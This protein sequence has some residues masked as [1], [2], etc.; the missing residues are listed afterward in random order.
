MSKKTS[1]KEDDG[2]KLVTKYIGTA[3]DNVKT[4]A[5]NIDNVNNVAPI[6]ED[7]NSIIANIDAI[8]AS[9]VNSLAAE[10]SAQVA[11]LSETNASNSENNAAISEGNAAT[12][13]INS[14]AYA[15]SASLSESEAETSKDT[16]VA[17][18]TTATNERVLAET[19]RTESEAAEAAALVSETNSQILYDAMASL[20]DNFDDRYLGP[21]TT[22]PTLD[23]DGDVLLVGASYF[24][25]T[26]GEL[27]FW[28]GGQW[29]SPEA[30]A[31]SSAANAAVSETN[32][33]ASALAASG[34]ETNTSNDVISTAADRVQTGNDATAT[35]ADR[36]A[37]NND[38]IAT[39]ADRVQTESDAVSTASDRSAASSSA[40]AASFSASN[41]S[42]SESNAAASA[43]SIDDSQVN[44]DRA[45]KWRD[46]DGF[47][48]GGG[49]HSFT[50]PTSWGTVGGSTKLYKKSADGS[51]TL[52]SPLV[53]GQVYSFFSYTFLSTDVV[54][55]SDSRQ[56]IEI[57]AQEVTGFVGATKTYVANSNLYSNYIALD[58]N[59]T[60]NT[61]ESIGPTGSGANNIWTA[62]DNI[63]PDATYL[64][65]KASIE[66]FS[67][68]NTSDTNLYV[69]IHS[70]L[71]SEQVRLNLK[72]QPTTTS[73]DGDTSLT[74]MIPLD[75]NNTFSAL[76]RDFANNAS[77]FNCDLRVMSFG[78]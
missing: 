40:S 59:L 77:S 6:A 1:F 4:V 20:F 26:D 74:V 60:E 16:A 38:A 28:D 55:V 17:N 32:A 45:Y 70:N 27:K 65:L 75:D 36:V 8:V 9:E 14:Q 68:T 72:Y 50:V 23:N 71:S 66:V 15:D 48:A 78:I 35:A 49:G 11:A 53:N 51:I 76:W 56:V 34:S 12:S 39:A 69:I 19:A 42:T 73:S 61:E 57:G 5:D 21:K 46:G 7:L 33:A 63:P 67:T 3:Y 47:T 58:S 31:S 24:D 13:E 22:P 44:F 10:A 52:L 18:A 2:T 25:E 43:A 29:V 54:F 64:V 41:A 62:L 37:T 30:A